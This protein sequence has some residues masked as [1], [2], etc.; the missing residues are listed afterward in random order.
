MAQY[1]DLGAV[2]GI[3]AAASAD[4]SM[5]ADVASSINDLIASNVG[6]GGDMATAVMGVTADNLADVATTQAAVVIADGIAVNANFA[7]TSPVKA[8]VAAGAPVG[9]DGKPTGPVP[10][11]NNIQFATDDDVTVVLSGGT[12]DFVK[13]AAGDDMIQFRGGSASIDTGEGNDQVFMQGAT[14][15]QVNVSSGSGSSV[16]T[17]G[18]FEGAKA[19]I[20]AGEGFDR[21]NFMWSS[22]ADHKF[23]APTGGKFMIH[24]G[25]VTMENV[26]IVTFDEN[27]DGVI[28]EA[29]VLATTQGESLIARLYKV[30]LGRD[31]VDS[32]TVVPDWSPAW[33][34]PTPA[35]Y[36]MAGVQWWF[37]EA[38]ASN[39]NADLVALAEKFVG[40]DEFQNDISGLSTAQIVD[41]LFK[42]AEVTC[43]QCADMTKADYVNAID[44]GS[45]SLGEAAMQIAMSDEA[46][47]SL[48]VNGA[49]YFVDDFGA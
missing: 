15:D 8:F 42:N 38:G 26:N 5:N 40:V 45:M 13:T 44:N 46:T 36:Q 37:T 34:E 21:V 43:S 41:M 31:V 28:D 48:G 6:P 20:D 11:G 2:T 25:D 27:G 7:G 47:A 3:I 14:G 12:G 18:G 32:S 30:A 35:N 29:T 10:G 4:G 24:S 19:T 39:S 17:F 49:C 22:R 33:A 1:D 9:E 16:F 23:D